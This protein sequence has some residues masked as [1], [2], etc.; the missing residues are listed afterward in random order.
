MVDEE[1][2]MGHR[3]NGTGHGKTKIVGE[4]TVP[5][6][7]SPQ[8]LLERGWDVTRAC[9]AKTRPVNTRT[10]ARLYVFSF[11]KILAAIYCDIHEEGNRISHEEWVFIIWQYE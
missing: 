3:L 9:A 5:A 6:S 4:K 2:S 7:Y 1:M 10:I 11:I 8:I